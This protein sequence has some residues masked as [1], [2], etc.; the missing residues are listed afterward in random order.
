VEG[1]IIAGSFGV[2]DVSLVG[3]EESGS[4]CWELGLGVSGLT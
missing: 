3:V 2:E 4:F 1:M